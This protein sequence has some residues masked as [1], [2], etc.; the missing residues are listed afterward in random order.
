V[1][2]VIGRTL[3]E[4]ALALHRRGF[5]VI[6]RGV[7]RVMRTSPAAGDSAPVGTA[8]IVWTE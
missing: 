5:R 6:L 3:R 4:A 2:D 7:G 1:P 8:V